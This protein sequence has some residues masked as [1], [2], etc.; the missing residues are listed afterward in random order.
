MQPGAVSKIDVEM[1][2]QFLIY[3]HNSMISFQPLV[4][5]LMPALKLTEDHR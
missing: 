3:N 5:V 4:R 2:V 1:Y